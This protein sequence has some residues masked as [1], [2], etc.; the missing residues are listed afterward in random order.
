MLTKKKYTII[1][2]VLLLTVLLQGFA[3]MA[4]ANEQSCDN[5]DGETTVFDEK[6]SE[7][8]EETNGWISSENTPE[9]EKVL[10]EKD[11][12]FTEEIEPK[13]SQYKY[14]RVVKIKGSEAKLKKRRGDPK[15]IDV[16][17]TNFK[18][19]KNNG[20][21]LTGNSLTITERF[22]FSL[23][24]DASHHNDTIKDGDYFIVKIPDEFKFYTSQNMNFDLKQNGQVMAKAAAVP[25]AGGNGGTIRVTFTNYV[26][27]KYNI[28]GNL[29]MYANFEQSL[30]NVEQ[31]NI[32]T[33][34]IGAFSETVSVFIKKPGTIPITDKLSKY[35][36]TQLQDGGTTIVWNLRLNYAKDPNLKGVT[37][38]DE[39]SIK[40]GTGTLTDEHFVEDSFIL[41][42]GTYTDL[43]VF[44]KISNV[45]LTGR[46]TFDNPEKTKFTI[47]FG[48]ILAG[49]QFRMRYKS[50]FHKDSGM[51]VKNKAILKGQGK[52]IEKSAEFFE[53]GGGGDIGGVVSKK[54]KIVKVDEAT[55]AKLKDAE[56]KIEQKDTANSWILITD[57]D[58]V[59]LSPELVT[60]ETY[61]VTETKAPPGYVMDPDPQEITLANE[62][63]V[64][65][66]KN[67]IETVKYK[68]QKNWLGGD[69]GSRP[70]VKFQ[71]K[72]DGINYDLPKDLVPPASVLEWENLPKY[73]T[74]T[75]TESKYTVEE[76]P[77]LNYVGTLE[78]STDSGAVIVNKS[79]DKTQIK[80]EKRW[81][82]PKLSS[83][84]IELMADGT[85]IQEFELKEADS[86]KHVF[87]NLDKYSGTDGHEIVYTV[88]EKTVPSGY[89]CTVKGDATNGFIVE[90]IVFVSNLSPTVPMTKNIKVKK[91][92]IGKE[93]D[94]AEISLIANNVVKESVVLYKNKGWEHTFNNLPVRD[95]KGVTI[96]YNVE[97]KAVP[98]YKTSIKGN[99]R[100][101]FLIENKY[102]GV[103]H[104]GDLINIKVRKMWEG[105]KGEK[106]LIKLFA[107][108]KLKSRVILTEDNNWKHVFGNLDRSDAT[109]EEIAYSIK[110]Q[111]AGGYRTEIE[112][113]TTEG[114]I[115]K[116][117]WK[118]SEDSK[119]I[120][121]NSSDR[122][123][124]DLTGNGD[125]NFLSGGTYRTGDTINAGRYSAILILSLGLLVLIVVVRKQMRKP[126]K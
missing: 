27:G 95:E 85:K 44:T 10:N 83:A 112:G 77:V 12:D 33:I 22:R 78:S 13:K 3:A 47:N 92:W 107:N 114:F 118:K 69:P 116:N 97:E 49:K 37:F 66:F 73:K 17:I 106:A 90:N 111:K 110:E 15:E 18:L 124:G 34:A 42:E 40:P 105:K 100:E 93:G 89:N 60:G 75:N 98:G 61:R 39:L 102:D 99:E 20:A 57:N 38:T 68:L 72:R 6:T 65:T 55:G 126:K 48:D 58:G 31:E 113:N 26:E 56:F 52:P 30:I 81:L 70:T 74:G 36:S 25:G 46:I 86:W 64:L 104:S 53:L 79:T 80:V 51:T 82:G 122:N 24:W 32:F 115:V 94:Q 8:V 121:E 71:L 5:A 2:I 108:G 35:A 91:K 101:G 7:E 9:L 45:D 62:G 11:E 63:V 23:D 96:N 88:K 120:I 43:G 54:I 67:K 125:N 50:T 84:I 16:K 76:L 21:N 41:E 109:G 59:A 4:E 19:L 87:I 29:F 14:K 123:D 119:S 28:K 117:I 103:I 1:K